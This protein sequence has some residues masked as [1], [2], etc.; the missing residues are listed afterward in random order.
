MRISRGN[1][2]TRRNLPQCHFVHHMTWPGIEPGA[3]L[4]EA[5]DWPSVLWHGLHYSVSPDCNLFCI[6][7]FLLW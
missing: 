7:G 6:N 1:R 2:S 5:V 3:P 4:L